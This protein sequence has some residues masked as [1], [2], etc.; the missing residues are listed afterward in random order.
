M[1]S[2]TVCAPSVFTIHGSHAKASDRNL[3]AKTQ[4]DKAFVR[5]V[6]DVAGISICNSGPT[7]DKGECKHGFGPEVK[8]SE[9]FV[10]G[11]QMG[12]KKCHGACK[13]ADKRQE[14]T[15]KVAQEM[16]QKLGMRLP[17]SDADLARVK[18]TGCGLRD[19]HIWFDKQPAQAAPAKDAP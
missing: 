6:S 16:C 11:L 14:V 2:D 18:D 8:C 17:Q 9:E 5:C 10:R 4:E 15:F 7:N 13:D 3:H 19:M 12:G 1:E